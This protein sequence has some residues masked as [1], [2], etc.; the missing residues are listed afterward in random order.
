[1]A[2][3]RDVV[4]LPGK[5]LGLIVFGLGIAMLVFVFYRGFAEFVQAGVLAQTLGKEQNGSQIVGNF[6]LGALA[7]WVL[8]FLL[9]YVAS[10]VAGRGIALYQASRAFLGEEG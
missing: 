7:K 3:R 4:D 5:W 2:T 1:M 6:L 10:A 8:L 9:A